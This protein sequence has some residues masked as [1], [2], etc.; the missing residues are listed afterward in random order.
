[1]PEKVVLALSGT[2]CPTRSFSPSFN[3]LLNVFA[4]VLNTFLAC[5]RR[6]T[7]IAVVALMCPTQSF[8]TSVTSYSMY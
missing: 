5:T 7:K 2:M 4:L 3:S 1:M 8:S 6:S